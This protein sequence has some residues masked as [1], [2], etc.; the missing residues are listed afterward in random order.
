MIQTVQSETRVKLEQLRKYLKNVGVGVVA[1]SGGVDSTFLLKIAYEVL[2]K[3]FLAVIAVSETYP[4][5]E[6]N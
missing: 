6:Q 3:K 5:V 4:K 2:G 1:Y